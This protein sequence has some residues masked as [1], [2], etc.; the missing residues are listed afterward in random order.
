MVFGGKGE[1]GSVPSYGYFPH[2]KLGRKPTPEESA[3]IY[4]FL[5]T[6]G[7]NEKMAHD[8]AFEYPVYD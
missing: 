7:F 1:A 4:Y 3:E 2:Q 6:H 5:R 8:I